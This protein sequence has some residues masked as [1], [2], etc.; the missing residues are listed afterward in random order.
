M[1][2]LREIQRQKLMVTHF[3]KVRYCSC[4]FWDTVAYKK[5]WLL[6]SFCA[7]RNYNPLYIQNTPPSDRKLR[8]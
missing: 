1:Y 6:I 7:L 5:A 8:K 4:F 3:V 2:I